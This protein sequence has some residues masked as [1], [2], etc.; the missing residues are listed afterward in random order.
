MHVM[1]D[2]SRSAGYLHGYIARQ[3]EVDRLTARVRALEA[4]LAGVLMENG[5]SAGCL[6]GNRVS[7]P[8]E[9]FCQAARAAL[10]GEP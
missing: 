2:G 5:H 6:A 1:D 10:A 9:A 3:D 7:L 8:C 4:G